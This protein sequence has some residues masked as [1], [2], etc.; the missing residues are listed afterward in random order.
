MLI[1]HDEDRPEVDGNCD[2]EMLLISGG[3]C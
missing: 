2:H 3:A 1:G